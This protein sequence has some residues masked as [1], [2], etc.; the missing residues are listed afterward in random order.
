MPLHNMP[1]RRKLMLIILLTSL[2]LMLLMRGAF[3]AYE[4]VTFR[5]TTLRHLTTLGEILAAYS[6]RALAFENPDAAQEI[7]S[8]LKAER[9]IVS[10][11]LYD[12]QGR[13]F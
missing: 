3:L 6:T 7:L 5:Q 13:L 11:G 9:H 8:A 12:R 10:A 2:V 1:I 4:Y